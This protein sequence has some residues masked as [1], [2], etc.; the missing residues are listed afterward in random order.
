[1]KAERFRWGLLHLVFIAA[2]LGLGELAAARGWLDPTFFGQPSGVAKFLWNNS[3]KNKQDNT[4]LLH[5]WK[6]WNTFLTQ[7]LSSKRVK[8]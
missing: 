8:S 5:A 4:I 7:R 2:L 6:C 3:Q 1:M